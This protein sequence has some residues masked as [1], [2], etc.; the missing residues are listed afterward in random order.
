MGGKPPQFWEWN[1][2]QWR[3]GTHHVSRINFSLHRE[4]YQLF[5]VL[6][7]TEKESLKSF[8]YSVFRGR[9]P[10]RKSAS[11]TFHLW[12][13]EVLRLQNWGLVT[14]RGRDSNAQ[15]RGTSGS[16]FHHCYCLL[17]KFWRVRRTHV[18]NRITLWFSS[19]RDKNGLIFRGGL[20]VLGLR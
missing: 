18:Q 8:L 15:N 1:R 6:G 11:V 12:V 20:F 5:D 9:S 3:K 10:V 19:C 17:H 13:M 7:R 4:W 14:G 16:V 2:P